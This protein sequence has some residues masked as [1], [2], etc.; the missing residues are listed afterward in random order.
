MRRLKKVHSI[1]KMVVMEEILTLE[2]KRLH[3]KTDK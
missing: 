2:S 3:L 1:E